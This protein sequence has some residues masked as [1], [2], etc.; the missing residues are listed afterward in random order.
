MPVQHQIWVRLDLLHPVCITQECL[1]CPEESSSLGNS[2][3]A[4]LL[5]LLTIHHR[6][7]AMLRNQQEIHGSLLPTPTLIQSEVAAEKSASF[8]SFSF[9][10][11]EVASC[12]STAVGLLKLI[13]ARTARSSGPI[14]HQE[15]CQ[16]HLN[17][18]P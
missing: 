6:L 17:A 4:V 16:L 8:S 1:Q 12:L 9:H 18:Q 14:Q 15:S 3:R 10:A 2:R 11:D 5:L 13:W 7:C